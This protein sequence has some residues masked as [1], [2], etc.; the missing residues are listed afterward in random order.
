[1]FL[2]EPLEFAKREVHGKQ[3]AA[4]IIFKIRYTSVTEAAKKS[5]MYINI[6]VTETQH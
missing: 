1:V 4:E 2:G 5:I 6:R 3:V